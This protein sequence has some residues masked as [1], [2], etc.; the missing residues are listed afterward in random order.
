[1]PPCQSNCSY[2]A[3]SNRD[4]SDDPSTGSTSCTRV[5]GDALLSAVV[6]S[7][8]Q[9]DAL[10]GCE[11]QAAVAQLRAEARVGTQ[12]RRRTG[13]H[14]E[15]VREL[16]SA[17]QGAAQHGRRALGRGQLVVDLKSAHHCLHVGHPRNLEGGR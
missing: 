6:L 7:D 15:E 5:R 8:R 17:G 9:R 3:F 11:P 10:E 13:E 2:A 12:R 1:M 16:P 14:A 4:S